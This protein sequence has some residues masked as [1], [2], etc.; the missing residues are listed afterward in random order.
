MRVSII[1]ILLSL[2]L[3]IASMAQVDDDDRPRSFGDRLFLGGNFGLAFGNTTLI[4]ISPLL[5]YRVND[6]FAVGAGVVYN[7]YRFNAFGFTYSTHIVGPQA[8]ARHMIFDQAFLQTE[9]QYLRTDV[10]DPLT[11]EP[12][13]GWVPVWYVGGGYRQQL[14]GNSFLIASLLYDVI[15]D[16]NSPYASRFMPRF[17]VVLGL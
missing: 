6:K 15:D 11:F 14:G 4:D 8:F 5:G 16:P 9:Y 2:S 17:G 10:I 3:P 7:Y 1:T 13:R 12:S